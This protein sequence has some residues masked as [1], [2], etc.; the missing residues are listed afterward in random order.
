MERANIERISHALPNETRLLIFE[1]IA[2]NKEIRR[3]QLRPW[4][5]YPDD[6]SA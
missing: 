1:A 6:I 3:A 2:S 4:G 5:A